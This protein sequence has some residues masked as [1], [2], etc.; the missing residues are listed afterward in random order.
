MRATSLQAAAM[1][2]TVLV[3]LISFIYTNTASAMPRGPREHFQLSAATTPADSYFDPQPQYIKLTRPTT[4]SEVQKQ[5]EIEV[6]SQLK[7]KDAPSAGGLGTWGGIQK[8]TTKADLMHILQ[9]WKAWKRQFDQQARERSC[10]V[11]NRG[12]ARWRKRK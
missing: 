10:R 6:S 9:D 3:L 12:C 5:I 4:Q 1:Q 2:C 8:E 7:E 11:S